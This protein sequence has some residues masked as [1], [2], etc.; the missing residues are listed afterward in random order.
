MEAGVYHTHWLPTANGQLVISARFYIGEVLD[1]YK[2]GT[3]SRYGLLDS[4]ESF[5]DLAFLS[6]RV[7]LPLSG[8]S[9]SGDDAMYEDDDSLPSFTKFYHTYH[10]H[11][12]APISNILYHLGSKTFDGHD[13]S[14]P[15]L[16]ASAAK[17]WLTLTRPAV[18][19]KLLKLK[20]SGGK[21]TLV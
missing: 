20:I 11:T 9:T 16:T 15:R 5:A 14:T 7:Y 17:H 3:N 6:L 18:K 13:R 19:E 2:K 4:S 1:I 21:A 12:H 10:L 8:E